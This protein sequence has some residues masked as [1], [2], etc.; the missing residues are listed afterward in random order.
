MSGGDHQ[1]KA[2]RVGLV[3]DKALEARAT[4]GLRSKVLL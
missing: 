2:A 1:G 4:L 3:N